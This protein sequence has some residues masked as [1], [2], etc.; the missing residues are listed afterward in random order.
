[1]RINLKKTLMAMAFLS[2]QGAFAAGGNVNGSLEGVVLDTN[3]NPV[4]QAE[5]IV[6]NTKTGLTRTDVTEADGSFELNLP[7]GSYE[8]KPVK[9]GLVST[10]PQV[11]NILLGESTSMSLFLGTDEKIL[12]EMVVTGSRADIN[13][14]K[15][16]T[17]LSMT[18]EDVE[19]LPMPRNIEAV[20]LLAP[21]T[22]SGDTAFG[23]DKTLVSFG[24]SSV[25]ENVYYINGL[26]V[27]NFRNGL[28]GS[29]VPFE[30]YSN[31]QVK[32]GGYSAEFG[33][34]TGGVINAVTKH[35]DNE[36]HYGAVAYFSPEALTSTS[37][38]T[39]FSDGSLYDHNSDNTK[40]S[41]TT[42]FYV[43]GP[44]IKDKLF[45]YALYEPQDTEQEYTSRGSPNVRNVEKQ[46]DDFYGLDLL[47]YI[48]DNHSLNFTRFSD[49]RTITTDL[50]DDYDPSRDKHGG[51]PAST[52][53]EFRGGDNTIVRYDGQITDSFS[54]SAMYGKNEY[55][56][57]D[58]SSVLLECPNVINSNPNYDLPFYASCSGDF[59]LADIGGDEREAYRIDAEWQLGDHKLRFGIDNEVNTTDLTSAYPA[60]GHYYRYYSLTPGSGLQDGNVVP[61]ANG[62]GSDVD[63]IRYR[64]LSSGGS[65]ETEASAIYLEDIWQVNDY[66]E[67]SL[68]VRSES[69]NNKNSADE[70]FVKIDDQIA[71]RIGAEWD[72]T[73]GEGGSVIHAFWGRY[74]L[75]VANNTNARLSGS[76]TF[77]ETW[78]L[79]DGAINPATN[80]PANITADGIPTST[81]ISPV[82]YFSDGEIPDTR[83]IVDESIDPMYQD[84]YIIGYNYRINDLWN[85]GVNYIH[86]ELSST[87]DDVLVAQSG[88]YVLTNPGTSMTVYEPDANGDLV[89][90][91]YSAA[92]LGFPEAERTYKALQ[93]E[94]ERA[95]DGKWSLQGSYTYSES[96]GNTEGLVKSDNGQDDAGITTDFDF[97]TLMDG[98]YGDLPNDR[99]H[100]L[101]LWG[102]YQV[103]EDLRV[104]SV[105]TVRSGRP[106][107]KF[108]VGH[109][110]GD[111][112]YGQT[113][114]TYNNDT[115]EYE[116]NPRGTNGRT[117]TVT[118]IDLNVVYSTR[119]YE[120]DVEVR[121]DVLNLL[122]ADKVTEVYEDA[123]DGS[124]GEG[125]P[126]YGLATS[127]Q[128]PRQIRLGASIRF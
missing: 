26:N 82:H 115:G 65:F 88:E 8:V 117:P 126:R 15:A 76:E 114:Y 25:A 68:G 80:A 60:G 101:K 66:L 21:G 102:T 91:H 38:D 7:T 31:F 2:A 100:L 16:V 120:S 17:G 22:V 24:G 90:V 89:K 58:T 63:V 57:T 96:K 49:E 13:T 108:G 98:A 69:F 73:G 32:T 59:V 36:F 97:P 62:D 41:W 10:E 43:S 121:L 54:L 44:I 94:F 77:S 19:L 37:P 72:F 123:E 127:Y 48:T 87:I 112:D 118:T 9:S 86:R 105:L 95:W 85:V 99:P 12:E 39:H 46:D 83:E 93:F 64:Y 119:F 70:S 53:Y 75:P 79:D 125:D 11:I 40:E 20:A 124:P 42:D 113:Y 111:P 35:G 47:W 52:N 122:D 106:I 81:V 110:D 5:V 6:I 104:G 55:D 27:T 92:D 3:G 14:S 61:D 67:L 74:H 78:F 51:T 4:G 107:N 28:G 56:L 50:Y 34:S 116:F 71:P 18:L 33:R 103:M 30:F 128:S 1:M 45:F 29:S 109:P 84:E 23:D